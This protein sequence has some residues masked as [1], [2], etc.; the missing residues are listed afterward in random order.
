M[1]LDGEKSDRCP[2]GLAIDTEGYFVDWSNG[3]PGHRI[4]GVGRSAKGISCDETHVDEN[5]KFL[6]PGYMLCPAHKKGPHALPKEWIAWKATAAAA[7]LAPKPKPP[8]LKVELPDLAKTQIDKLGTELGVTAW[9]DS[10]IDYV[11]YKHAGTWRY[12]LDKDGQPIEWGLLVDGK[13]PS[14]LLSATPGIPANCIITKEAPRDLT[15]ALNRKKARWRQDDETNIETLKKFNISCNAI[16]GQLTIGSRN[17][18]TCDG[19][20]MTIRYVVSGKIPESVLGDESKKLLRESLKDKTR[21]QLQMEV[22]QAQSSV[23]AARGTLDKFDAD[24]KDLPKLVKSF[25]SNLEHA[26]ERVG[27]PVKS[28]KITDMQKVKTIKNRVD[29]FLLAYV[30]PD[31]TNVGMAKTKLKKV[32][33]DRKMPDEQASEFNAVLLFITEYGNALRAANQTEIPSSSTID[34]NIAAALEKLATFFAASKQI[35]RD[36]ESEL[37]E[38]KDGITA[39]YKIVYKDS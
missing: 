34:Q 18:M 10:L 27:V 33:F 19:E 13:V 4:P 5:K 6:I 8:P 37:C 11:V 38:F 21:E 29:D 28:S 22:A 20:Q 25:K 9:K 23:K 24:T 12:A 35:L 3:E 36:A 7:K 17:L 2:K 32:M 16:T 39:Y 15:I 30:K 14:W 31:T 26:L 1:E